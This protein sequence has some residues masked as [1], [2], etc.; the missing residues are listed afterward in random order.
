VVVHIV[1]LA[2]HAR[3]PGHGIVVTKDA[4]NHRIERFLQGFGVYLFAPADTPEKILDDLLGF[5]V[6]FAGLACSPGR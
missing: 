4:C 1:V 2:L 3:E 6:G 5:V